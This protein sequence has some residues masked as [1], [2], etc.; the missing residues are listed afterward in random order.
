MGKN[1]SSAEGEEMSS[2]SKKGF[3][4]QGRQGKGGGGGSANAR[5]AGKGKSKF[6]RKIKQTSH[7]TRGGNAGIQ[8]IL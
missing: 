6:E 8:K 7:L 4:Q 2:V 3:Y 5:L 1:D